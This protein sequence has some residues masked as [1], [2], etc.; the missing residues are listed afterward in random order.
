MKKIILPNRNTDYSIKIVK[1]NLFLIVEKDVNI[2]SD[3]NLAIF[4]KDIYK[5]YICYVF[6]GSRHAELQFKKE[7]DYLMY[8]KIIKL[9]IFG[10]SKY[11]YFRNIVNNLLQ[12]ISYY[13]NDKKE[14]NF[15]LDLYNSFLSNIK[16]LKNNIKFLFPNH[17]LVDFYKAPE[18]IRNIVKLF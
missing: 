12:L 16:Y 2:K 8:D 10:K 9:V 4:Y 5:N 14:L 15:Y 17:K 18:F 7:K 1:K 11:V 3:Y 6:S 13:K